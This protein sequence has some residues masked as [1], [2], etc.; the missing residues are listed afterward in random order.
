MQQRRTKGFDDYGVY[1]PVN[2]LDKFAKG[3]QTT[4]SY[5]M[6]IHDTKQK[7]SNLT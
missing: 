3:I 6:L 4:V 7:T 1:E 2:D 5:Y